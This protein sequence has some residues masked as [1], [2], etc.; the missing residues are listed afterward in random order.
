[1]KDAKNQ[2]IV[3][4][5]P[6]NKL[7]SRIRS[8]QVEP[9]FPDLIP[10]S[11]WKNKTISIQERAT[12]RKSKAAPVEN[13]ALGDPGSERRTRPLDIA[14]LTSPDF[15]KSEHIPEF[16]RDTVVQLRLLRGMTVELLTES[17]IDG[18]TV[19]VSILSDEDG[20]IDSRLFLSGADGCS[21]LRRASVFAFTREK[22]HVCAV[23]IESEP[24]HTKIYST[25]DRASDEVWKTLHCAAV[26]FIKGPDKDS[27]DLNFADLIHLFFD[28]YLSNQRNKFSTQNSYK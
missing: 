10:K 12:R 5:D 15:W 19:P 11:I 25:T 6:S 28:I 8:F 21:R 4:H 23:V 3:E 24:V 16:L 1:M 27:K 7:A 26:D 18:W 13:A 9:R 14:L 17:S 20:E 22:N 2:P